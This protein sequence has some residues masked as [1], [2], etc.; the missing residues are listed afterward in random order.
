MSD[1]IIATA[2]IEETDEGFFFLIGDEPPVGPYSDEPAATQAAIDF[3]Q[4][5][6]TRLADQMING[7]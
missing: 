7:A 5:A 4:A 1:R 3:L 6:M 2:E